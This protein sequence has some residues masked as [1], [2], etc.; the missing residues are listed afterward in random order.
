MG[1]FKDLKDDL[2][3]VM[4]E[5]IGGNNTNDNEEESGFD[6]YFIIKLSDSKPI[7]FSGWLRIV[8]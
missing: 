8:F 2:S 4:N 6:S 3:S 5:L 7:C 1:F